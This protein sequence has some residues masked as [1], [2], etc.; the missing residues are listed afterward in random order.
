M[1]CC[2]ILGLVGIVSVVLGVQARR[3]ISQSQGA[4]TGD[5]AAL[6]GIVLGGIGAASGLVMG[7]VGFAMFSTGDSSFT[8]GNG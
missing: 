8:F 1:G 4:L 6:A 2:G 7:V 5:G 3:E